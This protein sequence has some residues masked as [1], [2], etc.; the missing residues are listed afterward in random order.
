[1][2][3][4]APSAMNEGAKGP[5]GPEGP[6]SPSQE[7]EGG[8]QNARVLL[9][10]SISFDLVMAYFLITGFMMIFHHWRKG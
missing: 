5:W 4:S 3:G 1:M 6:P 8:V 10:L 2:F 9:D 7:L